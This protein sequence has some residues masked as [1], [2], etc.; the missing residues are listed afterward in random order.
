MAGRSEQ[1]VRSRQHAADLKKSGSGRIKKAALAIESP[2]V[3]IGELALKLKMAHDEKTLRA[4]PDDQDK[5]HKFFSAD[6]REPRMRIDG[7]SHS[8]LF[9]EESRDLAIAMC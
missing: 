6:V 8:P 3:R 9:G 1:G 5:I 7:H 4:G 2:I